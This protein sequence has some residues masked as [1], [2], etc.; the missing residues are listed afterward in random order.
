LGVRKQFAY[1]PYRHLIH[2]LVRGPN[3]EKI[4]FFAQHWVKEVEKALGNTVEIRGPVPS[5]IEKVKDEYRYQIWYFCASA[6][7]VV[8]V[9]VRLQSEIKW[10]DDVTQVLDV[11]PMSLM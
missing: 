9:L 3:V 8:P 7:K 5:P 2:H 6:T 11:D 4:K 10:P 1:P